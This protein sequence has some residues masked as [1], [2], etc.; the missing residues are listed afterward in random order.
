VAKTLVERFEAKV[1]PEALSGCWLWTA[2]VN[3]KGYGK[4][5]DGEKIEMAH[6][7]SYRLN[8]GSIPPGEVVC[9][10]CDNPACVNPDH[11]FLGTRSDNSKDMVAK[12]RNFVTRTSLTDE[13]VGRIR[14]TPAGTALSAVAKSLGITYSGAYKIRRGDR[15]GKI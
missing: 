1:S 4:M 6:R 5:W 2:A 3:N 8:A 13:Q 14:A 15:A 9:H 12:G 7:L 11:L 10:H